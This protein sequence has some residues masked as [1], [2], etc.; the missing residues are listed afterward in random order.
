MKKKKLKLFLNKEVISNLQA[1]S[2]VGG[3]VDPTPVVIRY[4]FYVCLSDEPNCNSQGADCD[5][6][7]SGNCETHNCD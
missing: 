3:R 6:G 5:C 4:S 1:K 7:T 2:V